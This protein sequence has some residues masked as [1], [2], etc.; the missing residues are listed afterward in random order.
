M[1]K[2]KETA[3]VTQSKQSKGRKQALYWLCRT[4][5]L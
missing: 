2:S 5:K 4:T 1:Q 3:H